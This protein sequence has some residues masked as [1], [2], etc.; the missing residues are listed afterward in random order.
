[1]SQVAPSY[2]YTDE[3]VGRGETWDS[4]QQ[5][6]RS[7]FEDDNFPMGKSVLREVAIAPRPRCRLAILDTCDF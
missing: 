1:M 7:I 3:N 2:R 4:V 5:Q 6:V